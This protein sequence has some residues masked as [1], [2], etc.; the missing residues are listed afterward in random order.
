MNFKNGEES[1]DSILSGNR[2]PNKRNTILDHLA[3]VKSQITSG[4]LKII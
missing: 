3:K 2:S 1:D 4:D